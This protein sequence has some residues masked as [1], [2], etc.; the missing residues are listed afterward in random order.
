MFWW[1]WLDGN[2]L[3]FIYLPSCSFAD[4]VTLRRV[5]FGKGMLQLELL[6]ECTTKSVTHSANEKATINSD[7][8][9]IVI[10]QAGTTVDTDRHN[11]Q[12]KQKEVTLYILGCHFIRASKNMA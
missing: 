5:G 11:I 9:N 2:T 10:S 4:F 7:P 1:A 8:L 6:S 3:S 12:S